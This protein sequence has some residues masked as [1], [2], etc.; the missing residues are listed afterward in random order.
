[1]GTVRGKDDLPVEDHVVA[2]LCLSSWFT[3]PCG[4]K[5]N[6]APA[7]DQRILKILMSRIFSTAL[8]QFFLV[9]VNLGGDEVGT[10]TGAV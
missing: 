6:N 7:L 3:V 1:M 8:T 10:K 9:S 4:Y 5:L 2:T